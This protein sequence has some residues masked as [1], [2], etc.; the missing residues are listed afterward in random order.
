[1]KF[2]NPIVS[3][4]AADPSIC[5]VDEDYYMVHS[6]FEYLPGLPILH[7]TDLV[8]WEIIGMQSTEQ[9]RCSFQRCHVQK[10]C[11]HLPSVTMTAH[12]MWCVP[13]S[14][15]EVISM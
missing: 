1:M 7:S 4:F 12:F 13:M 11:M 5:R 2:R 3:G 9:N 6:T 10:G 15:W 14:A 8:N